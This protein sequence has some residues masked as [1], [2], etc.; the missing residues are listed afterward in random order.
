MIFRGLGRFKR[1]IDSLERNLQM[2]AE[3]SVVLWGH[4]GL[5]DQVSTARA[6]ESWSDACDEVFVP[7]KKRN[8]RA[9]RGIFQY[10]PNVTFLN[11]E[12]DDPRAETKNVVEISR[13]MGLEVVDAGRDLYSTL[14][15]CFP[16]FGINRVLSL[17]AGANPTDLVSQKL[18]AH[19]SS[20]LPSHRVE[21]D[22]AFVDHHPTQRGREIPHWR[23]EEVRQ[24]IGTL[25][26][27][28]RET[29]FSNLYSVML[30]AK[31]LHLVSSAPLCLA[32]ATGLDTTKNV[33][34]LPD[35][36][37]LL[38]SDYKVK[39]DECIL[40]QHL[41]PKVTQPQ[42]TGPQS[43]ALRERLL[44]LIKQMPQ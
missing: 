2:R 37:S 29:H 20:T 14:A 19:L 33:C 7:V 23:L 17:C 44:L 16:E 24:R 26:F 28:D 32:L 12:S 31:E 13:Q 25:L 38:K 39:W 10:I 27:N 5:G 40:G 42:F 36:P 30:N 11:M 35:S 41:R 1:A 21:L 3:D 43:E 8:S 6:L 34:Y 9:L 4:L 22:Y 15:A 18:A